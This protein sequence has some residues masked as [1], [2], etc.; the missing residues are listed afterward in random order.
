MQVLIFCPL[1]VAFLQNTAAAQV[2]RNA[3]EMWL[4]QGQQ[5]RDYLQRMATQADQLIDEIERV[6]VDH[7]LSDEQ[8][9]KLQLAIKG[10]LARCKQDLSYYEALTADLNMNDG[11]DQQ[12]AAQLL[13][14]A[15]QQTQQGWYGKNSW[16]S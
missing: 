7:P 2:D 15:M 1:A 9:K 10:V 11:N 12:K 14:P 6:L 13:A 5:E 4:L 16:R 3:V 8:E